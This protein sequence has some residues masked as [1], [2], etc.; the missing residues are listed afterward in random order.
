MLPYSPASL[1]HNYSTLYMYITLSQC[2]ASQ[3]LGMC[4]PHIQPTNHDIS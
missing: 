4:E 3:V 1:M 2:V